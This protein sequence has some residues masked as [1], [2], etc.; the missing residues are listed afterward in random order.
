MACVQKIHFFRFIRC[1][2]ETVLQK[3]D[4]SLILQE[5]SLLLVFLIKKE[6][7]G[8]GD[9]EINFIVL[10]ERILTTLSFSSH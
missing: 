1:N 9:F 7:Y 5:I 6:V 3:M 2:M 8:N 4:N 10:K